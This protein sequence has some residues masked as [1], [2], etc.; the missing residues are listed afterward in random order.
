MRTSRIPRVRWRK[1]VDDT[2]AFMA[3]IL[4]GRTMSARVRVDLAHQVARARAGDRVEEVGRRRPEKLF[5][6]ALHDDIMYQCH[7][8]C[9]HFWAFCLLFR[10][11]T[12]ALVV[13]LVVQAR[14]EPANWPV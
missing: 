12:C 5:V 11:Q 13:E 4:A 2:R 1:G 7:R 8:L 10:K 14:E 6:R 9:N 3:L